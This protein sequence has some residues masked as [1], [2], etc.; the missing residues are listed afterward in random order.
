[1][2]TI[3]KRLRLEGFIVSDHFKELPAF[4]SEVVPA[5]KAGKLISRETICRGIGLPRLAR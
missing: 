4:H 1:M 3:A 2:Q 5:L